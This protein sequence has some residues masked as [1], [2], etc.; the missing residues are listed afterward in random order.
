MRFLLVSVSGNVKPRPVEVQSLSDLLMY[1]NYEGD[2]N[3]LI[4]SHRSLVSIAHD[5]KQDKG[6]CSHVLCLYDGFVEVGKPDTVKKARGNGAVEG[7]R[8]ARCRQ[9][10]RQLVLELQGEE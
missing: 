8:I 1:L 4:I 5:R 2:E 10:H 9:G 7:K 3:D 6:E